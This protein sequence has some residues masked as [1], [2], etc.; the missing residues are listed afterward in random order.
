MIACNIFL[1][2]F[3]L[4]NISLLTAHNIF[5]AFFALK[6]TFSL[7][8]QRTMFFLLSRAR[9]NESIPTYTLCTLNSK[10]VLLDV[11]RSFKCTRKTPHF[12]SF[13]NHKDLCPPA[14]SIKLL[15]F[16][17]YVISLDGF[18]AQGVQKFTRQDKFWISSSSFDQT[19]WF[20]LW[21]DGRLKVLFRRDQSIHTH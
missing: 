21:V 17:P 5:F 4:K 2:F 19:G 7:Y 6:D 13:L 15:F 20:F 16:L 10:A 8:F 3:V 9:Q 14:A 18:N 1:L 12:D 11:V